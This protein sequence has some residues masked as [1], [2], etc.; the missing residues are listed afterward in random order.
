M[1]HMLTVRI[2]PTVI[3]ELRERSYRTRLSQGVLVERALRR[4]LRLPAARASERADRTTIATG[5]GSPP[6]PANTAQS[7]PRQGSGINRQ[8]EGRQD[9]VDLLVDSLD[10]QPC[11][12]QSVQE[13]VQL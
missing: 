12:A 9:D 10:P 11:N 4:M 5:A 8:Y 6:P 1:N 7:G 13:L 3:G 2:D